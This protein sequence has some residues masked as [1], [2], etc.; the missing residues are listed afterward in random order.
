M[1]SALSENIKLVKGLS[2]ASGT[3]TRNGDV[4]DM[5]GW[6]GVLMGV[7]FATIAA[8][9]KPLI[10]WQQ[11]EASNLSDAADLVE[12]GITVAEDD[13]NQIF[14]S[15]L[16]KPR[17]RYVR[18]VVEKDGSNASG[19]SAWYL[20]YGGKTRPNTLSV[21]DLVT[22]EQHNSPVEGTA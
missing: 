9:A 16:F 17:K 20:L 22:A 13:D 18:V 3:V 15:D 8:G 11:G 12:T 19:E 2:Y 14:A 10:K 4:L 7:Q 5:A 6:D 21:T 1:A